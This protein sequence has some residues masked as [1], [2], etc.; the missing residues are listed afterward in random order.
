VHAVYTRVHADGR[1]STSQRIPA[2]TPAGRYT[3]TARCGGGNFGVAAH[4]RID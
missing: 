2:S 4:V 1:Y 3:I